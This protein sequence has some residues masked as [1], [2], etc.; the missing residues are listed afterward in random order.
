MLGG[1]SARAG[2]NARDIEVK[3]VY[4][5]RAPTDHASPTF[6]ESFTLNVSPSSVCTKA[7]MKR[8]RSRSAKLSAARILLTS[9]SNVSTSEMVK[10][11]DA[12]GEITLG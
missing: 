5:Q 1:G 7:L 10:S 12:L 6:G 2:R 9:C 8:N 11:A 4:L 3:V